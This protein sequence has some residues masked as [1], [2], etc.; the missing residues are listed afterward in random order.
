MDR[1]SLARRVVARHWGAEH[2]PTPDLDRLIARLRARVEMGDSPEARLDAIR[3]R[4]RLMLR[5]LTD[6]AYEVEEMLEAFSWIVE[7]A[8]GRGP[9][10]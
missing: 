1:P 4:A 3:R 5:R 9:L 7:V 2:E 6:P 10:P 8:E